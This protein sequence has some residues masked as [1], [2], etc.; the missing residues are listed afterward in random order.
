[1]R[2]REDAGAMSMILYLRQ[3]SN[4]KLDELL[5]EPERVAFF[6]F[7]PEDA[8]KPGLLARLFGGRRGEAAAAPPWEPPAEGE[9]IDLDKAWHAIHYLLNFSDW[10]GK[11]PF[12][13]LVT[14]GRAVGDVDVG[15]G[16]ARGL[17]SGQVRRFRDA[18]ASVGAAG[19]SARYDP[20]ELADHDVYPGIWRAT[21][22]DDDPLAYLQ[23]H[24]ARLVAFLDRCVEKNRGLLVYLT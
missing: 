16:P 15:Y 1:M 14:G 11:E 9:C 2:T 4:E 22:E 20:D 6:L 13:Y 5:A 21:A 17:R 19:L 18:V 24:F 3:V 10:E 7:G 8:P 12:C 23:G